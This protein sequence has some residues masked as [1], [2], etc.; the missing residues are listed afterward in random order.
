MGED[1]LEH[2]EVRRAGKVDTVHIDFDAEMST[3]GDTVR[4]ASGPPS[5]EQG[6]IDVKPDGYL[7][8]A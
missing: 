3:H 1:V 6:A 5:V 7:R 8:H 4:A 2:A